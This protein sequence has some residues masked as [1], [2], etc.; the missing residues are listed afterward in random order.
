MTNRHI[1]SDVDWYFSQL[2]RHGDNTSVVFDDDS[3]TYRQLL[4]QS[5]EAFKTAEKLGISKDDRVLLIGDFNPQAVSWLLALLQLRATIIPIVDSSELRQT[6]IE[7]L[8]EVSWVVRARFD[9]TVAI[10]KQSQKPELS[11]PQHPLLQELG[12]RENPGLILFT[13]G[14]TGRPKAVVHDFTQLLDKFRTPARAFRTLTFLLFDHWGGLNTLLHSLAS[15]SLVVFPRERSA[16]YICHLIAKNQLELLPA[17]PSFLNMVLVSG[18]FRRHDLSS[19]KLITYGAEPMPPTTLSRLRTEFP[20]VQLKQTYGLIELGVMQ[21]QSKSSDSLLVK[22]GGS[23]YETRVVDGMLEIKAQ[24]SMLGYLNAPAP[25]TGDGFFQTGD[26][27]EQEGEYF[28]ILGR[29]SEI[30]NVGG[31]KVHPAEVE[32]ALLEI[33]IVAD[34]VV[35]GSRHPISGNIVCADVVL[36]DPSHDPTSART[37]IRRECANRLEKFKVPIQIR[38]LQGSLSSERQ[39]RMRKKRGEE[40]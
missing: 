23:G 15:G 25:I 12:R 35:Y 4:S 5:D 24:S 9:E 19:L 38:F 13:S 37:F 17:S 11:R 27:V 10:R 7:S 36:A 29:Q 8:C 34:A 16:D 2:S 32:S 1:R 3:L 30:I 33:K 40:S 31:E 14:S 28:R 6:E 39:K 18:A 20:N 22:L 21:T 26:Q